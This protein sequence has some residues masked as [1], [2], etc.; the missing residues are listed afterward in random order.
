MWKDPVLWMARCHNK[1][2]DGLA[3]HTMDLR[4]SW[5]KS[6]TA[7]LEVD[8]A[9]IIVQT[10]GGLREGDCAAASSIIGL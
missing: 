1:V 8:N 7:T 3:D 10:D 2:A 6:F 9:N 5:R 4:R